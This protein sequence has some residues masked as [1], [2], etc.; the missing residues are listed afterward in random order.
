MLKA[1]NGDINIVLN[2]GEVLRGKLHEDFKGVGGRLLGR[3]F[4][5]KAAYKQCALH[6]ADAAVSVFVRPRQF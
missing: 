3:C 5:L 6:P 1:D 2:S 4:D